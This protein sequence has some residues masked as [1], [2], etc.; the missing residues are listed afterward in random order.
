MQINSNGSYVDYPNA[1]NAAQILGGLDVIDALSELYGISV[2]VFVDNSE[3]LD[4]ENTPK[5][6]SQL[7]LLR[8]TDDPVLTVKEE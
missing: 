8:V 3:C 2:P 4:S 6:N 7:V 1:N 5:V